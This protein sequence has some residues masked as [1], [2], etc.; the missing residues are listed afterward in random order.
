MGKPSRED[1]RRRRERRLADRARRFEDHAKLVVERQG[2]G[3]YAQRTVLPDGRTTVS[4][5][6]DVVEELRRQQDRFREKF[7]RD[8]GPDDPVFFDPDADEPSPL[9]DGFW[10]ETF[11]HFADQAADPMLRALAL[12]SRDLGYMVTEMNM[13]LFSAHEVE[14]FEDAVARHLDDDD[15]LD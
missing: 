12:A 11:E 6:P 14:A 5:P 7:G 13:H 4:I 1:K 10:E 8:P 2:D 9:P 3:T 15:E